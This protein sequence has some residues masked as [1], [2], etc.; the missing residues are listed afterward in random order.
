MCLKSPCR[1]TDL[2]GKAAI[3]TTDVCA[4]YWEKEDPKMYVHLMNVEIVTWLDHLEAR[5]SHW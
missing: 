2:G 3:Q 4:Y 1:P 5:T